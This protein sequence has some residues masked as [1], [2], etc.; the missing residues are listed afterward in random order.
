MKN[1]IIAILILAVIGG[2]IGLYLW[3]KP[4]RTAEHETPVA[5]VTAE[6]LFQQFSVDEG[7]TTARYIDKTVQVSGVINRISTT[8]SG[9]QRVAL[10]T[11]DVLAEVLCTMKK[12]ESLNDYQD[13]MSITIKGICIGF[14]TDVQLQQSVVV[15]N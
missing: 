9:E 1:I 15:S 14:D 7:S 11:S 12:D 3:N 5:I 6:D 10:A 2:G 4:H 8:D 13:G